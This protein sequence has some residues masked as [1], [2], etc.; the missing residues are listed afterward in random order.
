NCLQ[1]MQYRRTM[2]RQETRRHVATRLD[3]LLL[4]SYRRNAR[5]SEKVIR[6]IRRRSQGEADNSRTHTHARDCRVQRV[7]CSA[8]H[9][10][11]HLL[12]LQEP[13]EQQNSHPQES[14]CGDGDTSCYQTDTVHRSGGDK[15]TAD[16]GYRQYACTVRGYLRAAGIC[17]HYHVHV[18]VYRRAVSAQH[19]HRH[20]VS[21]DCALFCLHG[22]GVGSSCHHDHR[23]GSH[24]C[25]TVWSHKMLVGLQSHTLLLDS[26]GTKTRCNSSEFSVLAEHNSGSG[27]EVTR[28]PH[29]RDRTSQ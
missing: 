13:S 15:T 19:D 6:W 28:E 17:A 7:P 5:T 24:H 26:G 16:P 23:L 22:C 10:P 4:M 18:D 9:L 29:K 21:R 12:P 11:G 20:R 2:G 1:A 14:V 25:H 3:Q 27:C 8:A